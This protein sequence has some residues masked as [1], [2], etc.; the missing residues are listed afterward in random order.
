[1]AH[2]TSNTA[3]INE[4]AVKFETN[5]LE[6]RDAAVW[7]LAKPISTEILLYGFLKTGANM[8]S[9]LTK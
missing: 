1:M 3:L 8:K 4:L 5:T 9:F 7:L 6:A 2:V